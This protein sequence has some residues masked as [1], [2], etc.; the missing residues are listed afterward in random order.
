VY[1]RRWDLWHGVARL[2][3]RRNRYTSLIAMTRL[4][5]R[6]GEG[7]EIDQAGVRDA[8]EIAKLAVK[9]LGVPK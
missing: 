2:R 7:I 1:E 4:R 9:Q 8:V 3:S 6:R 5:H